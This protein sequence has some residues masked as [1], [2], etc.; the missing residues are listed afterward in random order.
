V[1]AWAAY[2]VHATAAA[3][4]Y[5]IF[6]APRRSGDGRTLRMLEIAAAAAVVCAL[7][8]L[9]SGPVLLDFRKAY[10]YAGH[11]A[12][13][14]PSALY[15][16][17][18]AQCFVNIPIVAWLF[19]P[20]T[21]LNASVAALAFSAGGVILL[22]AAVRRMA[23]GTA[24]RTIVWLV[25]LCG[26]IYYSV[27]IGNTTHML[28][29]PLLVAFDRLAADRQAAAGALLAGAS[30]LK[31]P[32]ALFLPYFLLRRNF[33]AAVAMAGCA[34]CA[35]VASVAW[36]G[37]DLHR[38][39]FREFVLN[40]GSRPI[41]AYNVQSVNG[42]LAHLLTRGHLRDWYPI[43]A[44]PGFTM[45]SAGITAVLVGAAALSCWR[46]GPPRSSAAR[47]VEL[48]LVLCLTILI[49]PISWTHYHLLLLIPGAALLSR[50]ASLEQR[51]RAGLVAALVLIAPPV[52]ELIIQN[53]IGNALWER[54]LIS[55]YFAGAV[56]LLAVL[57]AERQRIANAD[58]QAGSASTR[59]DHSH[60]VV[61]DTS[62]SQQGLRAN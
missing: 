58:A 24:A 55:H 41:A 62:P 40:Q 45:A 4:A 30:L 14:D 17:I 35:L 61:V 52:V 53:R 26:P 3:I 48:W 31:P 57:I 6:I 15:G 60:A 11:A 44:G 23:H 43:D 12:I 28:L 46:A 9:T 38:F 29:L 49:A 37:V 59:A 8:V 7:L 32:L 47:Q 51:S 56:V 13:T 27:R 20:L 54:L 25:L 50:W 36:F 2:L 5:A 1:L 39:W 16:C 42:F 33:R 18:R 22:L 10:L 21:L 34:A 19:V